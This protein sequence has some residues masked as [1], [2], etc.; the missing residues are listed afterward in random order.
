MF[1]KLAERDNECMVV[2]AFFNYCKLQCQA[3]DG[4]EDRKQKKWV[5]KIS[6]A[7][8]RVIFAANRNYQ[9]EIFILAHL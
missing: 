5:M 2:I 3:N 6:P 4:N 1:C 8:A 7:Y 9:M